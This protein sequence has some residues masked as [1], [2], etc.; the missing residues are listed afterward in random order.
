MANLEDHGLGGGGKSL[1]VPIYPLHDRTIFA[2]HDSLGSYVNYN[3]GGITKGIYNLIENASSVVGDS[4]YFMG[5]NSGSAYACKY[6]TSTDKWTTLANCTDDSNKYWAVTINDIVYYGGYSKISKYDPTNNTHTVLFTHSSNFN[7]AKADTDGTDIYIF[8]GTSGLTSAYKYSVVNNTLTTLAN[9]PIN[10]T[11]HSVK[12]GGDGY[13]YLFGGSKNPNTAYKYNISTNAYTSILAIPYSHYNAM[14]TRI[15][16]TIYLIDG[17]DS[18]VQQLLYAY[19]INANTYTALP[20][21]QSKRYTG[22][23]H[24][25]DYLTYIIGGGAKTL[26]PTGGDIA[27]IDRLYKNKMTQMGFSKNTKV[28]YNGAMSNG[29]RYVMGYPFQDPSKII[30]KSNNMVVIP[31]DGL[32]EIVGGDYATIEG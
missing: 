10:M 12:Y 13:F 17:Y 16:S 32:Y 28:Y 18:S 30:T 31:E 3:G 1:G 4:I 21:L 11:Q 9:I 5:T 29:I 22:H 24:V 7:G 25:V 2:R 6:N 23:A 14:I 20:N 26:D 27:L 19:N 8:G 15:R